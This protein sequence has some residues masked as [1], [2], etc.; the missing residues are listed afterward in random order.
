MNERPNPSGRVPTLV[1][2]GVPHGL[3]RVFHTNGELQSEGNYVSGAKHGVFTFW[4]DDGEF[5]RRVLFWD[6]AEVWSTTDFY[7]RPPDDLMDKLDAAA[8]EIAAR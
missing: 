4:R 3:T 6:N 8:I 2:D 7:T 5:V 1:V